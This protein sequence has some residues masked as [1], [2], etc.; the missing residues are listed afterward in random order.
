MQF[1][2]QRPHSSSDVLKNPSASPLTGAFGF[3][4][5][6]GHATP[7]CSRG[8][9]GI[10]EWNPRIRGRK[11]DAGKKGGIVDRGVCCSE[12]A[13]TLVGGGSLGEGSRKDKFA[14]YLLASKA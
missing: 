11:G 13:L 14:G 4:A 10:V 12:V 8:N 3:Q 6:A 5:S 9:A 7:P 2:V 1:G